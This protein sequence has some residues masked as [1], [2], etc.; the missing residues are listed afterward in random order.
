MCACISFLWLQS[1]PVYSWNGRKMKPFHGGGSRVTWNWSPGAGGWVAEAEIYRTCPHATNSHLAASCFDVGRHLTLM[2]FPMSSRLTCPR[3]GGRFNRVT[4]TDV[5][6]RLSACCR[7]ASV[8]V[9]WTKPLSLV[10]PT[11]PPSLCACA[12]VC[13]YV[14][15]WGGAVDGN[16]LSPIFRD[17]MTQT[18]DGIKNDRKKA[19]TEMIGD[20]YITHTDLSIYLSIYMNYIYIY[21]YVS[22]G[23]SVCVRPSLYL[24]IYLSI[25]TSVYLSI[26][27]Y[28]YF[29]S[30][31]YIYIYLYII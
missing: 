24:F 15:V 4:I 27:P 31:M 28:N 14:C 22:V 13:V 8:Q 3:P 11:L 1:K 2:C 19:I 21:I 29:L 7:A 30:Y 23:L 17:L 20:C 6:L 12:C 25:Y 10:C 16:T 18:R 5:L 9:M 26:H